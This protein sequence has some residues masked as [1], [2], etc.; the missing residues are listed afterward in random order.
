[1]HSSGRSI[2]ADGTLLQSFNLSRNK[3]L[4][5]LET[6][7]QSIILAEDVA[8]DFLRI[9]L[10]SVPP[11]TPL[12]VVIIYRDIRLRGDSLCKLH[13]PRHN[14]MTELIWGAS[15]CQTQHRVFREMYSVRDFRL[16]FC[17]DVLDCAMDY[18]MGLMRVVVEEEKAKG[19]WN[20][21]LCEPLVICERRVLRTRMYDW[22]LGCSSGPTV[23]SSAM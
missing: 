11:R 9:V 22:N 16:V 6:T 2:V 3:A 10:S 1:M 23:A 14:R 18:A 20:Y 17:V 7:A 15:C 19:W 21:P 13:C 8:S 4:R 12:D 5:T